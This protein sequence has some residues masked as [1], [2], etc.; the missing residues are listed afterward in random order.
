M[1]RDIV[2]PYDFGSWL[3][4]QNTFDSGISISA[5]TIPERSTSHSYSVNCSRFI[6]GTNSDFND[7]RS[8]QCLALDP[9]PYFESSRH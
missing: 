6:N 5:R 2:V 8:F 7:F 9:L 4:N 3:P 1:S